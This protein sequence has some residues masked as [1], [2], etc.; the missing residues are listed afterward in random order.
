L[1]LPRRLQQRQQQVGFALAPNR[2]TGR[3]DDCAA[4]PGARNLIGRQRLQVG[5]ALVRQRVEHHPSLLSCCQVLLID[6]GLTSLGSDL[7]GQAQ[8]LLD[9][10]GNLLV[11]LSRGELVAGRGRDLLKEKGVPARIGRRDRLGRRRRLWTGRRVDGVQGV[12]SLN[13]LREVM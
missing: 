12:I 2:V 1:G 8:G 3:G 7:G 5:P 11:C 10:G 6:E 4:R 9:G 13:G